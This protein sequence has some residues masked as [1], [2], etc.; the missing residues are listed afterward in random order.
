VRLLLPVGLIIAMAACGA[1]SSSTQWF[2]TAPNPNG[3]YAQVFAEEQFKG[4]G[5]YV[6][7]PGRYASMSD[8][9]ADGRWRGGV[10][11]VRTGPTTTVTIWS[12]P[13]Y[14]GGFVRLGPDQRNARVNDA[15]KASAA[16]LQIAC[17]QD[18][19]RAA[20]S[21]TN[22]LPNREADRQADDLLRR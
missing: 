13:S 11:S 14:R 22:V 4:P 18:T 21:T 7:G 20:A 6:N 8:L 19:D 12:E 2:R 16:S 3:C 5:D 1:R 9:K 17:N 10:R 15:L